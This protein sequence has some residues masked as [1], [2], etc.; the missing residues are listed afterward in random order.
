MDPKI[1]NKKYLDT[2]A[3]DSFFPICFP[4]FLEVIIAM[5]L[6]L[7]PLHVT[8]YYRYSPSIWLCVLKM[9]INTIILLSMI[10]CKA[11]PF[12][13]VFEIC[14]C[15]H[16]FG[17]I[18]FILLVG[19]LPCHLLFYLPIN[20]HL[21]CFFLFFFLLLAMQQLTFSTFSP[22]STCARFFKEIYVEVIMLACGCASCFY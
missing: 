10:L 8:V 12:N 13:I 1:R 15:C 20:E 16:A 4:H 9:W 22:G 18:Q 6:F 2:F 17:C 3:L 14:S 11:F 7:T 21:D 19:I 5:N